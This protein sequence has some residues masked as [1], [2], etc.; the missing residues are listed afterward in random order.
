MNNS[1]LYYY[2]LS[3]ARI[4]CPFAVRALDLYFMLRWL[5]PEQAFQI[6]QAQKAAR[7]MPETVKMKGVVSG[8]L[9]LEPIPAF[10][11][12]PYY[13]CEGL[14]PPWLVMSNGTHHLSPVFGKIV[15]K[16]MVEMARAAAKSFDDCLA[17]TLQHLGRIAKNQMEWKFGRQHTPNVVAI[18][19]GEIQGKREL[20]NA[21]DYPLAAYV[22][23][24]T[25]RQRIMAE[26]V[27][28][29]VITA[30]ICQALMA[31]EGGELS[32]IDEPQAA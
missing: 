2:L 31:L 7:A 30:R 11:P 5:N 15:G 24:T 14:Q 13:A 9:K 4:V 6:V 19:I 18:H 28:A 17:S 16:R 12:V 25:I 26:P 8:P 21:E 1:P 3:P 22:T 10:K 32:A 20:L 27:Q 29:K 23:E